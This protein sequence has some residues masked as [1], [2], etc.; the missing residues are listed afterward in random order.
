MLLTVLL[1]ILLIPSLLADH[2]M[3]GEIT[4]ECLP[5]GNYRFIMRLYRECNGCLLCYQPTS[6]LLTNVPGYE[7]SGITVSLYPTTILGKKDLSP[8]CNT[9]S[10]FPHINCYPAPSIANTGAV[11]E[12]TYTSDNLYPSG[13]PFPAGPI[14]AT[15]WYFAFTSCCRNPCANYAG[16]ISKSFWIRAFMYPYPGLSPDNCWD[17]SPAFGDKPSTVI[18]TGY[19]FTYN[20]NGYDKELDSLSYEWTEPLTALNTPLTPFLN[21]GYTVSSPLPGPTQN[22][23]NIP[24]TVNAF[25]GEVS[26]TSYTSGAYVTAYKVTAY[27]CGIKIAEIFREMQIVLLNCPTA[28]PTAPSN[29]PP[30]VDPPF[31]NPISGLYSDYVDTVY[32]GSIVNF[33]LSATDYD[34]LNK[35]TV[36]GLFDMQK[37]SI[38]GSGQQFGNNFTSSTTGCLNP[39]CATLNPPPPATSYVF[40]ATNFVWQTTCAHIATESPCG[41]YT[42]SYNFILKAKDDF[43]PAP[44]FSWKTITIVVKNP[45]MPPPKLK[46][47][48][49]ADNGPVTLSWQISDTNEIPNTWQAYY[50]YR[51]TNAAG[52]FTLLDTIIFDP[53][54]NILFGNTNSYIDNSA[55]GQTLSYYYYVR[56]RSGCYGDFQS[57][58]SNI[59]HT[60]KIQATNAGNSIGHFNWDFISDSPIPTS[61]NVYHLYQNGNNGNWNVIDSTQNLTLNKTIYGCGPIL[62]KVSISDS[63]GC[64]SFSSIDTANFGAV[65]PPVIH[66]AAV[67][68]NGHVTL[69]FNYPGGPAAIPSFSACLVYYSNNLN[70]PYVLIDSILDPNFIDWTI[71]SVSANS[72][73][74]YFYLVTRIDCGTFFYSL[75]SDTL[76]TLFLNVTDLSPITAKLEWNVIHNPPISSSSLIYKVYRRYP[77]NTWALVGTSTNQ[78]ITDNLEI[79]GDSIAYRIEMVDATGCKSISNVSKAYYY[80]NI[81]PPIPLLDSVSVD[82]LNGNVNIGWTANGPET[83]GYILFYNDNGIWPILDTIWGNGNTHYYDNK[84]PGNACSIIK[85]Y[86]I[87]AIDSCRNFSPIGIS[88]IHNT[89]LLTI[90][91]ADPC[92]G[93]I[94][95]DWNTYENMSGLIAYNIY[96]NENYGPKSLLG[97][98]GSS[99]PGQAPP[100]EY[101]HT[102]VKENSWYCYSIQAINASGTVSASSCQVCYFSSKPKQPR[103]NYL[104]LATVVENN[105]IKLKLGLDIDAYVTEYK[106]M[107]ST[108]KT[109][110]Y[111]AIATLPPQSLPEYIFEDHTTRPKEESYYYYVAIIAC[112]GQ[113]VLNSDTAR[114]ILVHVDAQLNFNNYISWNDYE[115][116]NW[117]SISAYNLFRGIDGMMDPI[118]IATLPFGK[119]EYN[120]DISGYIETQGKFQYYVEAIERPGGLFPFVDSSYSN[121]TQD[122]QSSLIFIP[123]AFSPKGYNNIF[124]PVSSFVDYNG[125]LFSIY[126]RWGEL[127]FES[128]DPNLGWDGTYKGELVGAGVYIY[129]VKCR[130]SEGLFFERKSSVMVIK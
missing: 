39:P 90:A 129:Y 8:D 75:P 110:P 114:T 31:L 20:P 100:T 92:G 58:P 63:L 86:A 17:S 56:S 46:C 82:S 98:V 79:C 80:D 87:A 89:L 103:F 47:V 6:N 94:K 42:N 54:N 96:Y 85:S 108:T 120:D 23:A 116:W 3:G 26:F 74:L 25:T 105:Y 43:C 95:L 51:S 21:P 37:V 83:V 38:L 91:G 53:A 1:S 44:A 81:P 64:E 115:G 77:G 2:F 7:N 45:V 66:C 124:K 59:I 127:I 99:I 13:V 68:T 19:P 34:S 78:Y 22:P 130:T 30:I 125:Y 61:L 65:L 18:C 9:N 97:T 50:I 11:E 24:A 10:S 71:N 121:I 49:V 70:G 55:S 126:N 122:V 4:W 15:G 52:P 109:G 84:S 88:G 14:P 36:T 60:I 102:N 5:N 118:P 67:G 41:G 107:R 101:I 113:S 32:A 117:S 76:N 16:T 112:C 69:A 12:W 57:P 128:K 93:K 72:A 40:T 111:D 119:K 106:I 104:K 62:F 35:D 28:S 33:Y 123:N 73:A 48:S 29:K 27:K